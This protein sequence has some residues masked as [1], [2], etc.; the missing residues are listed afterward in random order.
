MAQ[1]DYNISNAT[2]ANFRADVNNM[3]QAIVT[4]NSGVT[5]PTVRFPGMLW[6]DLSGGGDG[7]MR[8]RNQANSAWLTDIGMD[9][10]ARTMAQAAQTTAN[11]AL[12][13]AGGTM[14]G[15]IVMPSV[16]PTNNQAISRAWTDTLYQVKLPVPVGGSLL[17]GAAG[18]WLTTLAPGAASSILTINGG[19]PGWQ[20]T[21]TVASPGIVVRTGADGTIDSSFIPQVASGLRFCGTFRPAVNAEYP[22]TGGHGSGG[23]PA[24][25]DFWVIDGLTTGGYTYLTGSLAGVTVYN[26]DSIA[27]NGSGSWF[28]MGSQVDLQGYLKTDGSIAMSGALNMG[29]FAINNVNGIAGRTG[30]QVPMTNFIIDGTNALISP[31]RTTSTALPALT[32]GQVATDVFSNQL[33]VGAGSGNTALLAVRNY[34]TQSGYALGDYVRASNYLW[35]AP[36]AVAAGAFVEAQW[37]KVFDTGG[38]TITGPVLIDTATGNL[39]MRSGRPL[40][41]WQSDNSRVSAFIQSDAAT[42]EVRWYRNQT[43]TE[44]A[45]AVRFDSSYATRLIADLGFTVLGSMQLNVSQNGG[46][47]V[48][49][50]TLGTGAGS[51]L[52]YQYQAQA[53]SG[54]ADFLEAFIYRGLAGNTWQGATWSIR[55]RVDAVKQGSIEFPG[56]GGGGVILTLANASKN[57]LSILQ[58]NNTTISD[59]LVANGTVTASN[60]PGSDARF[61]QAIAVAHA[62]DLDTLGMYSFQLAGTKKVQ[63]GCIA[64]DVEPKAPEYVHH[65]AETDPTDPAKTRDRMTVDYGGLAYEMVQNLIDRVRVLEG[66]DERPAPPSYSDLSPPPGEYGGTNP[67]DAAM[68][69]QPTDDFVPDVPSVDVPPTNGEDNAKDARA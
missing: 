29:G 11:A 61:K 4:I 34:S 37:N 65:F 60:I 21:G 51:A 41:F 19:V 69:E 49:T 66:K 54:N 6:L 31:Q 59:N 3:A 18:G 38:G 45:F 67:S 2:G 57:V 43:A 32:A 26:G 9:Q 44:V 20:P 63:R 22:T 24:I 7:V 58:N 5:E 23:A 53:D 14:T 12:P 36:A 10:T 47:L 33:V 35:R 68:N 16:E 50:G 17:V 55:R 1:H 56:G 52:I 25:G 28:R 39:G 13:R 46:I 64:Q 27:Y 40:H 62:R 42:G 48:K 30:A 8:R 15:A